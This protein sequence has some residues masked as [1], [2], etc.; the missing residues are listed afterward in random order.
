MQLIVG[1]TRRKYTEEFKREAVALTYSPGKTIRK[2]AN[3]LG[4]NISM[5]GSWRSEIKRLDNRAFL[6]HGI[7]KLTT[8]EEENLKL[9][10]KLAVIT[11][12][13]DILKKAVA[14]FSK[15]PR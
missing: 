9:K 3:D 10:R 15:Q 14:I 4:I 8:S 5:L 2:I 11:E 7:Q 1:G 12:E 13:R 6:G